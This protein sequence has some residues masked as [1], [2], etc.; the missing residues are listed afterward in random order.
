MLIALLIGMII[1][2]FLAIPPGPVAVSVAKLSLFGPKKSAYEFTLAAGLVD[3]IFALS[4][5]FA[6]SAI[7]NAVGIFASDHILLMNVFQITIV[8]AFILYGIYSLIK[9]KKISNAKDQQPKPNKILEKLSS[10]GP[11]F[12]GLAI[13]LSNLA[14][15]TFLPSLGYLSFHV[16]TYNF[17]VMD[18]ANKIFYSLGFCIGNI[19]WLSLIS[20]II[21]INRHKLTATFQQRLQQFAGITF[22]SFGTFIGYRL[23]QIIHWQELLRLILIF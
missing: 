23:V 22:I 16:S 15:P 4:A 19:F 6:A 21:S 2:F 17:F 18:F 3:F 1:G 11:F 10:R 20:N 5:T 7:A 14:N 8:V 13:A 9:S 12:F